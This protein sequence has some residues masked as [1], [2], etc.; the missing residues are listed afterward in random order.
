M[1]NITIDGRKIAAE[2][3]QTI[4]QAAK[5]H[6]IDIPT[7]CYRKHINEIGSC[8]L[9]MVEI[10]GSDRVYA[11]CRT[12]VRE[13]MEIRTETET[14]VQYRRQM[15]KLIL[16]NHR[17]DCMSCAKNG[18]CRLQSLCNRYGVEKADSVGA[19]MK[20]EEKMPILQDNPYLSYDPGKC[21]HCHTCI[22]TC[23]EVAYNGA[24]KSGRS[25]TFHIVEAPFGPDWK[26]TGCESCGNCAAACPTGALTLKRRKEYREWEVTKV[27]TTCPHCATG[28]QMDLVVKN[29]RIVDCEAADG[30]S[31]HRRLC[32]KGRSG[33]FDFVHSPDRLTSPL[34]KDRKTGE[35]REASWEE[36]IGFAAMREAEPGVYEDMG[37]AVGPSYVRKG[38]GRQILNAFC[39]EAVRCGA[40][41]FR[42]SFRTENAASA[43]LLEACGFVFDFDSGERIDPRTGESYVVRNMKKAL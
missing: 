14:L 6:G 33:S 21:I 34:I 10:E 22:S 31:N 37:V 30:P 15:L 4:L 17:L 2:E 36:A 40:R 38:Y 13:G 23:H 5:A 11:S 8:R 27:R 29:N 24:L 18:D 12:K 35:F 19:R 28:C 16:S 41:E 7:L 39:A 9:C 43:G 20:I 3:G 32:V 25:G 26:S 1:L 42:A